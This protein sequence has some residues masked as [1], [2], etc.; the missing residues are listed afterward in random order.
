MAPHMSAFDPKQTQ[1]SARHMSAVSSLYCVTN[2]KSCDDRH[3][4]SR[5][6]NYCHVMV[7]I[8]PGDDHEHDH[9]PA[10]K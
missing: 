5:R 4:Q 2:R 8:G 1:A 9:K 3:L 6:I 10:G 7:S